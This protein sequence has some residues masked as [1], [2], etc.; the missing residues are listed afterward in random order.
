[1]EASMS[2]SALNNLGK[3]Y[4]KCGHVFDFQGHHP[5]LIPKSGSQQ[6]KNTLKY[7]ETDHFFKSNFEEDGKEH[8]QHSENI[9][10]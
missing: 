6:W 4:T 9:W 10:A 3:M 5:N 7:L 2:T 8:Q 1:M